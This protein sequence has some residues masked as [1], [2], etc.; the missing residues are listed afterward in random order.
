MQL[1]HSYLLQELRRSSVNIFK[2][3]CYSVLLRTS[4]FVFFPHCQTQTLPS[5]IFLDI[6]KQ[7]HNLVRNVD[8]LQLALSTS[9]SASSMAEALFSFIANRLH[10]TKPS[11]AINSDLDCFPV[12]QKST[13]LHIGDTTNHIKCLSKTAFHW[14]RLKISLR[15]LGL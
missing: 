9:L 1:L 13:F 2:N 12:L 8:Q 6:S 5:W 11:N 10:L 15:R 14:T 3:I 4:P 7:K